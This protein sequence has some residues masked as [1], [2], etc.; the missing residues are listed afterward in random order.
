MEASRHASEGHRL[1]PPALIAIAWASG[2]IAPVEITDVGATMEFQVVRRVVD[3]GSEDEW[4]ELRKAIASVAAGGVVTETQGP[5]KLLSGTSVAV[6]D[7]EAKFTVKKLRD[8]ELIH[9][10]I[11][12]LRRHRMSDPIGTMDFEL[13]NRGVF[14]RY[15]SNYITATIEIRVSGETTKGAEVTLELPLGDETFTA[16]PEDGKWSRLVKLRRDRRWI[17]GYSVDRESGVRKY[18][19]LDVFAQKQESLSAEDYTKLKQKER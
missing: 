16:D 19:R 1:L 15:R 5:E 8:L 9:G 10:K 7:V 2:C 13:L 6:R 18:F 3:S 4:K 17:Y 14:L 11:L 12:A